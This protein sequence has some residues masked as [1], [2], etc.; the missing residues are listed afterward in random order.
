VRRCAFVRGPAVAGPLFLA[1]LFSLYGCAGAPRPPAVEPLPEVRLKEIRDL[2]GGSDYLKALAAI[3]ESRRSAAPLP[4]ADIA[5]LASEA[6]ADLGKAFHDAV[7][8]K[9]FP[10]ALRLYE[11]A[12]VLG[13][14]DLAES[15]TDKSLLAGIATAQD[16]AGDKVLALI[17]RLRILSLP[18]ASDGDYRDALAAAAVASNTA[19]QRA[20]AA[21]MKARG[22]DVPADLAPALDAPPSFP[23]MISGTVTILVNRGIKVENGVGY[24][25]QVIGSGFFIDPRGYIV[26]NHHVIESEVDPKYEGFSRLFIRLSE[27]PAGERIPAKVV[28]YDKILDLALIKAEITPAYTFGGYAPQ[29]LLPGQR[30]YAIGSPAGLEKTL[31]SGIVSATGRRLLQVGDSLQVDVPLNPGNSGGPLMDEKGDLIGIVFAGLQ[32]FEGL[33]FAVPYQWLEKA[34]PALYKGGEAVHPWLGMAVAEG[35]KGLEVVYVVPDEP[36]AL[37]GIRVGDIVESINGTPFSKLA[38]IQEAVLL[39][40]PPTLLRI[41]INRGGTS[42]DVLACLSPRPDNPIELS[43]QRDARDPVLYPLFGM[44]LDHVGTFLWKGNYV[45]RRVTPGSVADESGI[46]VDDPLIIQDWKVDT[47]K[48]YA[49]LQVVIQKRRAGFLESAIQISSYLDTDNFI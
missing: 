36:A 9:D 31:T 30:I 48:G 41:R 24:P 21:Q 19:A 17:T 12:R 40:Q 6:A 29:D 43:L 23:R 18:G 33:N 38:D 7:T 4:E 32:Q 26:T 2:L 8:T 11:S 5:P 37:A 13:K 16:A 45:V 47:D 34:L 49:M 22:M 39:H 42:Q 27:S 3:D 14:P 20:L 46:S 15:W 25:D 10:G 44:E 1:L 35:E 28:G